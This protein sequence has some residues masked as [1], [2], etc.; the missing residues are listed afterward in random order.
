MGGA[1]V[2][3][4]EGPGGLECCEVLGRGGVGLM[5]CLLAAGVVGGVTCLLAAAPLEDTLD[6]WVGCCRGPG[7]V[8]V[9]L[10]SC[11]F[12]LGVVGGVTCLLAASTIEVPSATPFF[13]PPGGTNCPKPP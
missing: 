6:P 12:G 9:G 7:R 3:E 4:V 11:L 13:G 5:S 10:M 2:A 8:G 1:C